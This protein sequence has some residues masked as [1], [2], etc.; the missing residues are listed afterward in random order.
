MKPLFIL[1]YCCNPWHTVDTLYLMCMRLLFGLNAENLK[2]ILTSW[3]KN[4]HVII[5]RTR[6]I[7][8]RTYIQSKGVKM[9]W[10]RH[11]HRERNREK[12]R[13]RCCY[14]IFAPNFLA[15][16]TCSDLVNLTYYIMVHIHWL[17]VVLQSANAIVFIATLSEWPNFSQSQ[18]IHSFE[19]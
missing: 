3:T 13:F 17:F 12:K 7:Y 19:Q 16:I 14:L 9:G 11:T 6:A 4:D 1:C 5:R 10:C 2:Y 18:I 8:V 15:N